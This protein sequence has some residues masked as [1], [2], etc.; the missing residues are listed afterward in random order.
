[1]SKRNSR[2]DT[3]RDRIKTGLL[4]KRLQ[5]HVEGKVEMT[6]TQLQAARILLGK[7]LPDMKAVDMQISQPVEINLV[8]PF[9]D[10]QPKP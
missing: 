2:A 10:S 8:S 1:M 3:V 6:Q 4:L 7:V 9:A 5:D